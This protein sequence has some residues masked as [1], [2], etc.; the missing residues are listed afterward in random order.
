MSFALVNLPLDFLQFS[1][2]MM[3]DAE[4]Y[5]TFPHKWDF[6][7]MGFLSRILSTFFSNKWDFNKM[8]FLGDFE[9]NEAVQSRIAVCLLANSWFPLL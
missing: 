7:K 6:N 1:Q 8:G 9:P 2:K 5:S 3:R 4:K